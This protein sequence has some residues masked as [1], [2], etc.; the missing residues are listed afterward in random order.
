MK[1][2]RLFVGS[3]V[4]TLILTACQHSFMRD[5]MP[6]GTRTGEVRNIMIEETLSPA[7]V[8]VNPGDEIRWVNKRQG[9]ARVIF[10]SPVRESLA[11]KRNFGGVIA[12]GWNEYTANLG[13]NGTA[14]IC[15]RTV[16]ELKYVV[17]AKS[18]DPIG[19]RNLPG[20]ITVA[21]EPETETYP[22]IDEHNASQTAQLKGEESVLSLSQ[23]RW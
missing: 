13:A 18:S 20:S 23:D 15:F 12:A 8:S 11:C 16:A 7:T 22:S 17:R 5:G 1:V 21:S 4:L 6:T 10:L 19:E 14:S 2:Q 3:T 9:D